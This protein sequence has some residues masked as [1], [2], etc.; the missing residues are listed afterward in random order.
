MR[1][2]YREHLE[3]PISDTPYPTCDFSGL[4]IAETGDRA[5]KIS[6]SDLTYCELV[7]RPEAYP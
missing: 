4:T 3:L 2:V 7:C 6:E 1:A 5:L